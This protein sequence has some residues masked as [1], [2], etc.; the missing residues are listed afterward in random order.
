MIIDC[1]MCELEQTDACADC[2]VTAV[3]DGH[4]AIQLTSVEEQAMR[5][6]SDAGMVSPLRLV[7]NDDTAAV[8][9]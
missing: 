4:G 3:L 9:G 7:V 5:H 1:G 8:A 2:F 6:L